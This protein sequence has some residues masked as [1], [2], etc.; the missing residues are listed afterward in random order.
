MR[1]YLFVIFNLILLFCN[2]LYA[3]Q[4]AIGILVNQQVSTLVFNPSVGK[5]TIKVDNQVFCTIQ[6]N[7]PAYLNISNGKIR[8]T[9]VKGRNTECRSLLFEAA[10][11]EAYFSIKPVGIDIPSRFYDDNLKVKLDGRHLVIVNLIDLEKY[12]SGV[13]ESEGGNFAPDEYYK[14]QAVLC[15]TYL[16]NHL[17]RHAAEGY[18]LCDNVHCQAYNGRSSNSSIRKASE[19]TRGIAAFDSEGKYITAAFHSNCGGETED[20]KNVWLQPKSYLKPVKDKYCRGT[21]NSTWEKKIPLND[22]IQYLQRAGLRV[23]EGDETYLQFTQINR[24]AFYKVRKD[25]ISFVRIRGDWKL[26]SAFFSV[27]VQGEFV[28]LSGRGYG[29]GIGL[30]QE[31]AMQ[32]ARLGFGY[33]DILKFY[34]ENIHLDDYRKL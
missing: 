30:C 26:R 19:V 11:N 16:L 32:M 17:T 8:L 22:W 18:E 21:K 7:E 15:R 29:H 23:V 5:Y 20:A 34:Y 6:A 2:R 25:S 10:S 9:T 24:Q 31:G 12:I 1:Y 3:Q 27:R 14:S 33:E 13:V 28:I 4:I